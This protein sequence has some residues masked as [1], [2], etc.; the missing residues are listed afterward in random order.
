MFVPTPPTLYTHLYKCYISVLKSDSVSHLRHSSANYSSPCPTH[1]GTSKLSL[2]CSTVGG[3]EEFLGE[4]SAFCMCNLSNTWHQQPRERRSLYSPS[5]ACS[6][7]TLH[8]QNCCR[9]HVSELSLLAKVANFGIFCSH[10]RKKDSC[11]LLWDQ[12][13][14]IIEQ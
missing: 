2:L 11:D 8:L 1:L 4:I 7:R 3:V 9:I 10:T 5:C 6:E 13:L 14:H 12:A